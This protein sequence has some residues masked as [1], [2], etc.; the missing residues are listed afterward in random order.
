MIPPT[1]QDIRVD[2]ITWRTLYVFC[3][4]HVGWSCPYTSII[5]FYLS[6][7]AFE[8]SKRIKLL[9]HYNHIWSSSLYAPF[10]LFS[11][12]FRSLP[13]L[14]MCRYWRQFT[15]VSSTNALAHSTTKLH[16]I[17]VSFSLFSYIYT[18]MLIFTAFEYKA[19]WLQNGKMMHKL[20]QCIHY[21]VSHKLDGVSKG[22]RKWPINN[23][24]NKFYSVKP[25]NTYLYTF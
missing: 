8:I 23:T 9:Y 2:K 15:V 25:N 5:I 10:L 20:W 1:F 22:Y 7:N 3:C 4:A 11:S 12:I 6:H 19:K 13:P 21:I 16:R 14:P 17:P 18:N 24:N